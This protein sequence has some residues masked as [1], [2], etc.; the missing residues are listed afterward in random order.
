MA[1][2]QLDSEIQ[3]VKGVGPKRATL[4]ERRGIHRVEDI[5]FH[6]PRRYEDRTRFEPLSSLS[7][8]VVS[9]ISARVYGVRWVRTRARGGILDV[10]LTDG[11]TFVHAKWFNGGRLYH[12]KVFAAGMRVAG[13]SPTGPA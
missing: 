9:T 8:G 3:Y 7:P 12:Q 6:F 11:T 4:L 10:V 1:S 2:L 5:L 13:R